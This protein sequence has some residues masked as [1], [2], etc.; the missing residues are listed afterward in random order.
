MPEL[1]EVKI[2]S[3]YINYVNENETFIGVEKSKENKNPKIDVPYKRFRVSAKSRGK[4]LMLIISDTITKESKTI[5]MGMGMSGNWLFIEKGP[6]PKH[7]HL[8]FHTDWGG[9]LCMVDFRR[10]SRWKESQTWSDN[11]G[12][13]MLTE[14]DDFVTNLENNCDRKIFDKPIYELMLDQKYFNG[15][16]NFRLR[17]EILDRANQNPFVSAREAIQNKPMLKLCKD[18]VVEAY[19]LGGGQ[20]SQWTNLILMINKHLDNGCSVI[21]KKKKLKIKMVELFGLIQ[22]F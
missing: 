22:N 9:R 21:P 12:P 2:M 7:A 13:C 14:W 10:F 19:Q 15:M 4:E 3:E 18:I 20:L 16:G 5:L 17:A 11:R 6:T 1:A 8:I